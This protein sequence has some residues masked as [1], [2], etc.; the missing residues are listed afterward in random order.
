VVGDVSIMMVAAATTGLYNIRAGA[1]IDFAPFKKIAGGAWGLAL[2]AKPPH[3]NAARLL[4]DFLTSEE[5]A[6]I[7]ANTSPNPTYHP[8]AAKKSYPNQ[9]FASR[10]IEVAEVPEELAAAE[11]FV[12]ASDIWLKDILTAR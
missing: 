3:P 8:I 1:P 5:G 10:G 12:K 9:F 6:L 4:L 11:D 2:T 7:H